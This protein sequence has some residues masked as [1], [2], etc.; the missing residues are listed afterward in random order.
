MTAQCDHAMSVYIKESYR[1][2]KNAGVQSFPG[3]KTTM[4]QVAD[5]DESY[6]LKED[7]PIEIIETD[8]DVEKSIDDVDT[9][10]Y[11]D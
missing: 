10:E 7:I 5:I 11:E 4:S 9:T 2:A 3:N 8:K 6:L 1:S